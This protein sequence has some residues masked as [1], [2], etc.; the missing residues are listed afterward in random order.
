MFSTFY[1]YLP[2]WKRSLTM[3]TIVNFCAL[4]QE[5]AF[6]MQ[7]IQTNLVQQNCVYICLNVTYIWC[8]R[9]NSKLIYSSC[10]VLFIN[11]RK[12]PSFSSFLLC[13][14]YVCDMRRNI[15]L[16][17]SLNVILDFNFYIWMIEEKTI[18]TNTSI[19]TLSLSVNSENV[20]V[21]RVKTTWYKFGLQHLYVRLQNCMISVD[22]IKSFIYFL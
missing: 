6:F 12:D 8:S 15:V 18:T 5:T 14:L 1:I 2:L 9:V 13:M 21:I 10:H 3:V 17:I 20:H 4:S 7:K 16:L 22:N 19:C 11:D